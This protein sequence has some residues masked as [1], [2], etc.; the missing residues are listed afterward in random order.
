MSTRCVVAMPSDE[1]WSGR[2]VHMDGYPSH[3]LTTLLRIVQRDGRELAVNTLVYGAPHGWSYIDLEQDANMLG[4][5]R[6]V[7]VPGYGLK[8]IESWD[9]E[10][11]TEENSDPIFIEYVYILRPYFIEVLRSDRT[12]DMHDHVWN[13]VWHANYGYLDPIPSEPSLV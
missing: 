7:H 8:Y 9:E 3:M 1:G 11:H 10:W 6:A 2:Y 4:P 5:D 13:H 12:H